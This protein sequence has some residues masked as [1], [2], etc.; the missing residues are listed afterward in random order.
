MNLGVRLVATNVLVLVMLP[1]TPFVI[2][3]LLHHAAIT[4]TTALVAVY[5]LLSLL[6]LC[7]A[8]NQSTC[9]G[10]AGTF[11]SEFMCYLETGKGWAGL[12]IIGIRMG[13][14]KAFEGGGS[15]EEAIIT[16]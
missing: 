12:F 15:K 13:L 6:S 4:P 11:G 8:I 3:P 1:V 14:K 5:I 16:R 7:V 9:Y 2:T 10:V